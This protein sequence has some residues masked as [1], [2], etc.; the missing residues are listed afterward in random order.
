MKFTE[1]KIKGAYII[2]L[3][4]RT[5]ERGFFTRSFCADEFRK[6]GLKDKMMQSNLSFSK[7][8]FTLRGMHFQINGS[9][10]VKLVRCSKGEIMDVIIDLRPGSPTYLQHISFILSDENSKMLYVPE[11]FAHGF[12]TLVE[13]SEVFYQVSNLYSPGNERGIRWNDPL[14]NIKW[15]STNP[16]LSEKDSH[17]PDFKA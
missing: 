13:N 6:H 16:I 2:E 17:H 10:E 15:P 12:I 3:E 5:D 8:R 7:S 11:F 14:F 4:K 9:E 1:T